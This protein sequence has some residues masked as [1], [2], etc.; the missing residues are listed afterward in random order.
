MPTL[1]HPAIDIDWCPRHRLA[2]LQSFIDTH[3]SSGHVLARDRALVEWQHRHPND[4]DLLAIL[5]ADRGEEMVGILGLIPYV[6]CH[7]GNTAPAAWLA[8]W[9]VRPGKDVQV[10]GLRLMGEALRRG[11]AVVGTIG[12][13]AYV[14]PAFERL[15]FACWEQVP[16]WVRVT[17]C[18]QL[19]SLLSASPE[20]YTEAARAAWCAARP[21]VPLAASNYEIKPWAPCHA[22]PWDHTWAE[23]FAPTLVGTWRDAAYLEWRYRTHP[24][25]NYELRVA[26]D[27]AGSVAGL[28]V[29]RLETLRDRSESVIRVLEFLT[30]EGAGRD[31]AAALVAEAQRSN[32]MMVD[33]FCTSSAFAGPLEAVGF[34]RE[35]TMPAALPSLFQ[36]LDP[37]PR[38]LRATFRADPQMIDDAA[39]V[40]ASPDLY[41]TRSD[42]D[43]DRPN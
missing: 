14:M 8:T 30:T 20:H 13:N 5:V 21:T 42:C 3:W 11:F 35:D 17:R 6:F 19:A 10:A 12:A 39:T 15:G 7:R 22:E 26:V 34:V 28:T 33:F 9:Q 23:T 31:L 2:E 27:Q 36:P 16:R 38:N 29:F 24:R 32:V 1:D 41:Y 43:Q 4:P 37:T 18:D 25:F 40:F